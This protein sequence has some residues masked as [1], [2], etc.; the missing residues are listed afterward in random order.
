[1]EELN[2]HFAKTCHVFHAQ[3]PHWLWQYSLS[4]SLR[5]MGDSVQLSLLEKLEFLGLFYF[6]PISL[7]FSLSAVKPREVSVRSWSPYPL[8]SLT[9]PQEKDSP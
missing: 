1:M 9:L 5:G 3:T 2:P 8:H 7:L 4:A 6:W